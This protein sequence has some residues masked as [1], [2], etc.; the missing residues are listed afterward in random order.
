MNDVQH[1]LFE[2]VTCAECGETIP[3][4]DAFIVEKHTDGNDIEVPFCNESEANDYYLE[5]L[6][7]VGM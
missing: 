6:R 2:T 7:Q 1:D 3:R 4:L 5:Q